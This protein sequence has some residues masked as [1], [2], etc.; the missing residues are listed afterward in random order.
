[1]MRSMLTTPP[2]VSNAST[3]EERLSELGLEIVKLRETLH[4]GHRYLMSLTSYDTPMIKGPGV[5]NAISAALARLHEPLGWRILDSGGF[6]RLVH[7]EGALSVVVHAGD[8]LTGGNELPPRSS[9]PFME[10]KRMALRK[11][12]SRNNLLVDQGQR[13]FADLAQG[14]GRGLTYLLLHH[15]SEDEIRG[16]LSLPTLIK[17][18]HIVRFHERLRLPADRLRDLDVANDEG[19]DATFDVTPKE[20]ANFA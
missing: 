6:R 1:M 20:D 15:I 5:Y 16:E 10:G 9:Y 4:E 14:W 19:P 11:A 3:V 8:I 18:K 13:H 7:P 2:I 12:I 17:D